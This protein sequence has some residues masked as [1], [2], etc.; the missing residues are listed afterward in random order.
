MEKLFSCVIKILKQTPL[1]LD[2]SY[3]SDGIIV[4]Y[5]MLSGLKILK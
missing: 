1:D 2:P 3:L 4:L 5:I